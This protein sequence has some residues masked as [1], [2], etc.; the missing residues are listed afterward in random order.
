[1]P[2]PTISVTNLYGLNLYLPSSSGASVTAPTALT[3]P[4]VTESQDITS[5]ININTLPLSYAIG[6]AIELR[7][8]WIGYDSNG[9][10]AI[11]ALSP[12]YSHTTTTAGNLLEIASTVP[13]GVIAQG[14]TIK[15]PAMTQA[16]LALIVP[17]GIS[18]VP[19]YQLPSPI[20]NTD[21]VLS[22]IASTLKQYQEVLT[23]DT[24]A[25]PTLTVERKLIETEIHQ[26]PKSIISTSS[27]YMVKGNWKSP[28]PEY[29]DLLNGK[30]S[31][32]KKGDLYIGFSGIPSNGCNPPIWAELLTSGSTYCGA[33]RKSLFLGTF[34]SGSTEVNFENAH[35]PFELTQ[36]PFTALYNGLHPV[37]WIEQ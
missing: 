28:D 31:S 18:S 8:F 34:A 22:T 1:M 9:H 25:S 27:T 7:R 30:I 32:F 10:P 17:K 2:N 14:I 12:V 6:D 36:Q 4:N 23:P 21:T 11:S 19:I 37:S 24:E 26:A 33:V 35:I 20:A 3:A 29:F 5:K 13:T 15:T 16:R